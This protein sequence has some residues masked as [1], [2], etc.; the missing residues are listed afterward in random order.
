[1]EDREHIGPRSANFG[2]CQE[3]GESSG[4]HPRSHDTRVQSKIHSLANGGICTVS[5]HR[6]EA[7]EKNAKF[8]WASAQADLGRQAGVGG[9]KQRTPSKNAKLLF[10]C[11]RPSARAQARAQA[12]RGA[13]GR[14]GGRA[15][16]SHSQ[17]SRQ[18]TAA[19]WCRSESMV[20]SAPSAAGSSRG[21]SKAVALMSEACGELGTEGKQACSRAAAAAKAVAGQ[22]CDQASNAGR[23]CFK[24]STAGGW[25]GVKAAAGLKADVAK[26]TAALRSW[27]CSLAPP[28]PGEG[29]D[30]AAAAAAQSSGSSSSL[31]ASGVAPDSSRPSEASQ[32]PPAGSTACETAAVAVRRACGSHPGCV[33]LAQ[34][35]ERAGSHVAALLRPAWSRWKLMAEAR[36]GGVSEAAGSGGGGGGG[37]SGG[38]PGGEG[39]VS[40]DGEE[41][42]GEGAGQGHAAEQQLQQLRRSLRALE[43]EDKA[44]RAAARESETKRERAEEI[45]S[46]ERDARRRAEARCGTHALRAHRAHR[47]RSMHT[48][49]VHVHVY[50]LHARRAECRAECPC[51]MRVAS[52]ARSLTPRGRCSLAAAAS[53]R[54]PARPPPARAERV[55]AAVRRSASQLTAEAAAAARA[56]TRLQRHLNEQVAARAQVEARLRQVGARVEE[57]VRAATASAVQLTAVTE[58][59]FAISNV[60]LEQSRAAPPLLVHPSVVGGGAAFD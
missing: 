34:C 42:S 33:R 2:I 25:A 23:A 21:G 50:T 39:D 14:V 49:H 24:M 41:V 43:A 3:G 32:A 12:C 7:A 28:Q 30:G 58:T 19:L 47:T 9:G 36:V 40:L 35:G 11:T 8:R 22:A 26:V 16:Y 15:P 5:A 52:P 1:M 45:A 27:W 6:K 17:P 54:A 44:L 31:A 57:A 46:S 59:W 53:P 56:A 4:R 29:S 48:A 38:T 37:V 20:L 60:R 51:G 55:C 13:G 10:F 18:A